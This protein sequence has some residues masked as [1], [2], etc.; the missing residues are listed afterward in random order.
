MPYIPSL[1]LC[2]LEDEPVQLIEDIIRVISVDGDLC[3]SGRLSITSACISAGFSIVAAGKVNNIVHSIYSIG[4]H[5]DVRNVL[6]HCI[7]LEGKGDTRY[8]IHAVM[9][10]FLKPRGP[11]RDLLV[12]YVFD[13]HYH[14]VGRESNELERLMAEYPE[15]AKEYKRMWEDFEYLKGKVV[16]MFDDN[17]ERF[18][19]MSPILHV[20]KLECQSIVL[21]HAGTDD[22]VPN[23]ESHVLHEAL[24]ANSKTESKLCITPLLNHGDQRALGLSDVPL[25]FKLISTSAVFFE[26][27]YLLNGTEKKKT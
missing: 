9:G 13:D 18:L 3:P 19:L 27:D 11:L 5:A 24:K 26:P 20:E 23:T 22:V 12:A 14:N 15:E 7:E 16:E 17:K 21:I 1:A 4:T 6:D 8:T 2:D 10:S 25:I